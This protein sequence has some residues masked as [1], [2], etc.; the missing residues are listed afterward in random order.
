MTC[1][2]TDGTERVIT[3]LHCNCLK[4]PQNSLYQEHFE[5]KQEVEENLQ[6]FRLPAPLDAPDIIAAG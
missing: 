2:D 4:C 1:L 6:A 3:G 5:K